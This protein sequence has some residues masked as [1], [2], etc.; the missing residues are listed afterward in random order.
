MNRSCPIFLA[1]LILSSGCDTADST[2]SDQ[3]ITD[4]TASI[5]SQ[6]RR[7]ELV[8]AF[9]G[10]DDALPIMAN[11][12]ICDG[13]AGSDGMPVIFSH[14]IDI[15]TLQAGD[16]KVTTRSGMTGAITCVT[17]RPADDLG[18]ARTVLV[19]GQYGSAEDQPMKVEIVGNILSMDNS[20]NFKNASIDVIPLEAGPMLVLAEIVPKQQWELAKISTTLPFGGGSGC[21]IDTKQI[22]RATWSGGITKPGGKEIDDIERVLYK[23]TMIEE[24]GVQKETIPFKIA[25]LG[26]GDNNHE[27]CLEVSAKVHAISFRGGYL[28]DPREDLNQ[29]TSVIMSN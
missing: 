3:T 12:F 1:L 26:D 4:V 27:L 5:D 18:E 16:F 25:D 20:I 2:Q 29:D 21:P 10:L 13:A 24:D 17:L 15:K 9:Y 6:G 22:I 19:V 11:V 23:V 8:S 7:A 28:T 14:E